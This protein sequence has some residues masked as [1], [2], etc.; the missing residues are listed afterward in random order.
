[1]GFY[2]YVQE[3]FEKEYA[4]RDDRLRT[5]LHEWR[6]Q[7]TITRID[8]PTNLPRARALGYKAKKEFVLCRVRMPRGKRRRRRPDLGRKPAKNRKKENPGKPWQWFAEQRAARRFVN[9]KV[10][11]SY[12]VG[13]DGTAQYYEVIMHNP[14]SNKPNLKTK[15]E[16]LP[17]N[18]TKA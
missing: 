16:T 2:K 7:H 10:V 13:E 9:L 3:A 12:W 5:R 14:N 4:E 6:R 11:N 18:A 15:K 1:M 8:K 17:A